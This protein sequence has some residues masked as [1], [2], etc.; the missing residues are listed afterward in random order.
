MQDRRNAP[1]AQQ[2]Q[3][4]SVEVMADE[5]LART[6]DRL[7]R[8]HQSAVAAADRIGGD[9]VRARG[10]RLS[11]QSA[12]RLI[13][14]EPFADFDNAE[15]RVSRSE[16]ATKADLP[17]LLAAETVAA[18]RCQNSCLPIAKPLADQIRG[19]L[20]SGAIVHSDIGRTA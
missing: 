5:H 8:L 15:V 7:E 11:R 19:R 17:L 6:R 1:L 3:I 4:V 12:C 20:A 14:A 16:R 13:D 2:R 9:D 10:E 18:E